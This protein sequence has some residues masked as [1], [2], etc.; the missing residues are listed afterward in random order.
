MTTNVTRDP[1]TRRMYYGTVV[2][3]MRTHCQFTK[4]VYGPYRKAP[5]PLT[6][7]R[8]FDIIQHVIVGDRMHLID[9]GVT[10]KLVKEWLKCGLT[11]HRKWNATIAEEISN[12]L[13]KAKLPSE[14]PHKQHWYFAK[15]LLEQCVSEFPRVYDKHLV[16]SNVHNLLHIFDDAYRFGSLDTILAYPFESKPQTIKRMLQSGNRNLEQL[17]HRLAE[18][19]KL[20]NT[21]HDDN[22]KFDEL[23]SYANITPFV[24]IRCKLVALNTKQEKECV[25]IPLLYTLK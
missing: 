1:S 6:D 5:T 3:T 16:S 24:N 11:E 7:L 10:K 22:A 12:F 17:I 23:R 15:Q 21:Q 9:L 20:E 14:I 13:T 2:Q 8:N 25:F 18:I 4:N 19:D